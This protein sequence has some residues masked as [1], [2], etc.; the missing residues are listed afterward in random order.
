MR[1]LSKIVFI[2]IWVHTIPVWSKSIPTCLNGT[3]TGGN[4]ILNYGTQ[5]W[6]QIYFKHC[7]SC[8]KYEAKEITG[9]LNEAK[10]HPFRSCTW[11]RTKLYPAEQHTTPL[12]SYTH[13]M[14]KVDNYSFT[15]IPS[16]CICMYCTNGLHC[17]KLSISCK[18]NKWKS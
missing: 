5:V 6:T 17:V 9:S 18:G 7:I 14:C 3:F 11:W 2:M 13:W 4:L 1:W 16:V 15:C 8:D 12:P 10:L